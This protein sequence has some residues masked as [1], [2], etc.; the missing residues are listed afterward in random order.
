MPKPP[1]ANFHLIKY[2][3]DAVFIE[4]LH[5]D[6]DSCLDIAAND[7]AGWCTDNDLILNVT[8]T[9]SLI[10]SNKR[11]SP[12]IGDLKID[13]E[14]VELVDSFKYLGTVI[15]S[16]L[17]FNENSDAINAKTRKRLYIM[18]KLSSMRISRPLRIRCYLTFIECTLLY[19]ICTL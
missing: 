15:D 9:K 14:P 17:N 11:Y 6:D 3:D 2:A 8:K 13:D 12:E 18:K 1:S 10:L 5:R 7:L 19:H 4:L 16:K